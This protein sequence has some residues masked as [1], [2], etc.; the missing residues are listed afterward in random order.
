[1]SATTAEL[2]E[3]AR[4][5]RDHMLRNRPRHPRN[6]YRILRQ[7]DARI[8]E[9]EQRERRKSQPPDRKESR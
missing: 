5:Q 2:L 6:F 1:M 8:A 4:Q 7:L 9:L 3:Q